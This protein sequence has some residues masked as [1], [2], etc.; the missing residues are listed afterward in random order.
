MLLVINEITSGDKKS[1][2]SGQRPIQERLSKNPTEKID[3]KT[4]ETDIADPKMIGFTVMTGSI[5]IKKF[6]VDLIPSYS[7]LQL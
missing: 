1:H 5:Q 7:H 4:I 2:Y 6:E 3:W